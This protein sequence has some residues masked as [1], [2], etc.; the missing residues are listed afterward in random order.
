MKITGIKHRVVSVPV[1][2]PVVSSVRDST[3]IVYVLLDIYSDEEL[4]G[5]SYAQSFHIHGARA[6]QSCLNFLEN[7]VVGE[8][9]RNIER[10]WHKMWE[11]TKL[12]GHQGLATFALSM[13]DIALWDLMA[14]SLHVPVYRVLD[15]HPLPIESYASDGLWLV[16]PVEAARQAEVFVESGF[17]TI[18]MRLGRGELE[19]DL[20]AVQEVRQAV[21]YN[22]EILAD[23]NQGWSMRKTMETSEKLHSYGI[24]WLE[25][26]IEAED[27]EGYTHLSESIKVPITT[28]ENLYGVRPFHRFLKNGSASVY[29]PDLQR[30][31]GVSGWKRINYLME[32]YKV[33]SSLH[34]FPEFAVHLFTII[35]NPLKLEWVSWAHP[36][37]NEPLECKNGK[38]EIPQRPGFGMEWHEENVAKFQVG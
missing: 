19:Q 5:I 30:V 23:V 6:I 14:R 27:M 22:I 25:E 10:I 16:S 4:K 24:G 35:K 20:Q 8:D 33:P 37:F 3:E 32:E 17:T 31:G 1:K 2:Y 11:A 12:L 36:L 26:P 9:P 29:T 21:G 15:G 28:G 7:V 38:V 13:L 18:K 34:L